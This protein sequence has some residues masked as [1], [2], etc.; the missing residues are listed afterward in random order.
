MVEMLGSCRAQR[1]DEEVDKN[2][3]QQVFLEIYLEVLE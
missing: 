3:F 1:A 2:G